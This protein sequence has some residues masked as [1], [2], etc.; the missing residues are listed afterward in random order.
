MAN[1]TITV[2][3]VRLH[4]TT[5]TKVVEAG[6]ALTPMMPVYK[7]NSQYFKAANTSVALSDCKGLCVGYADADGPFTLATKG[8]ITI[9]ATLT[10]NTLYCVSTAGLIMPYDD[11]SSGEFGCTLGWATTA[12]LLD[13][14]IQTSGVAT[15]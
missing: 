10:V 12:A 2:A 13:L 8:L 15:P 3:D 6:I 14:Q 11:L 5:Q 4:S 7:S 1:L 9:G